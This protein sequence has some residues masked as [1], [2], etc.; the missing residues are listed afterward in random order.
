MSPSV[1]AEV[2]VVTIS[3]WVGEGAGMADGSGEASDCGV[4][5]SAWDECG[6]RGSAEG[7]NSHQVFQWRRSYRQVGWTRLSRHRRRCFLWL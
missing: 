4:D 6:A 3:A 5:A 1:R 7:V 2:L